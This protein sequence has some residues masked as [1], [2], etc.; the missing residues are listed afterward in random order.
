[1]NDEQ[2]LSR[3]IMAALRKNQ[4][5]RLADKNRL[6]FSVI[7][8]FAITAFFGFQAWE[9]QPRVR[10]TNLN[11]YHNVRRSS[12]KSMKI[13]VNFKT[14]HLKNSNCTAVTYFSHQNGRKVRSTISGY[15][16]RDNQL[17]TS[18]DFRPKYQYS[19]YNKFNLYIPYKYFNRGNY[20]GRVKTYCGNNFIG[21]TKK[22]EFRLN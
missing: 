4:S 6:I 19:T 12:G 14:A 15:R 18:E 11:V 8:G 7:F 20:Q 22:F 10:I 2:E 16:T 9:S 1:M 3:K 21:N 13:V 5:T 17:S